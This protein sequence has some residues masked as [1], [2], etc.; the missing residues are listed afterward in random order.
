MKGVFQS[1]NGPIRENAEV[2][3]AEIRSKQLAVGI[4]AG[5]MLIASRFHL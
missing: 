5:Q 2:K 4:H 1:G 3:N